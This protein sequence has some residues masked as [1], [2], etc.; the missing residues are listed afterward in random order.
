V[1]TVLVKEDRRCDEPDGARVKS[2]V[3]GSL[4]FDNLTGGIR[5]E[6]TV[7]STDLRSRRLLRAIK[8]RHRLGLHGRLEAIRR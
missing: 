6:S 8:R 7:I 3:F 5:L 4:A 1:I 2:K